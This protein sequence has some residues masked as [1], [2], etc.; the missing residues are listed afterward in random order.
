MILKPK[1]VTQENLTEMEALRKENAM[2]KD[3]KEKAKKAR[4]KLD[5]KKEDKVH[6]DLLASDAARAKIKSDPNSYA[7]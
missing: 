7:S 1:L 5:K 4:G 6:A 3:D 2:L